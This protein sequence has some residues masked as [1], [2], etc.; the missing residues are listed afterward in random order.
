MSL[1]FGTV[2]NRNGLELLLDA[3]NP[4]SFSG[5]ALWRDLSGNGRHATVYAE[6]AHDGKWISFNG[7]DQ[8]AEINANIKTVIQG[9]EDFTLI[10]IALPKF[11]EHVDNIVGWGN[12][13]SDGTGFSRT[14]GQWGNGSTLRTSFAGPSFGSNEL[15][16]TPLMYVSRYD[17]LVLNS[18]T[19]GSLEVNNTSDLTNST[20]YTWKNIPTIYPVTIAKT[21]YY[22]RY[23][24]VDISVVMMY[25]R[26]VSD[27]ELKSIFESFRGRY[28]L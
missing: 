8:Y 27:L 10:T 3:A 4:K 14:F 23:A 24:E 7:L 11:I 6:P 26:Y 21:N 19:F 13:N 16:N 5:G 2:I 25:S 12:A 28:N 17:A 15:L 22:N 9:A 18:R 20:T 1:N